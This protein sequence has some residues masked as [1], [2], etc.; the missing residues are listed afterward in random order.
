MVD[1]SGD[2][3]SRVSHFCAS[4]YHARSRFTNAFG[5]E[6]GIRTFAT[7][8]SGLGSLDLEILFL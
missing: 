8:K 5:G 3:I 6:N 7:P 4:K 1:R 2:T